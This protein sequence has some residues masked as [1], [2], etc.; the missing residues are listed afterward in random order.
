[1]RGQSEIRRCVR[2]SDVSIQDIHTSSHSANRNAMH[3][4]VTHL[5]LRE[6]FVRVRQERML[7]WDH[8]HDRHLLIPLTKQSEYTGSE[9]SLHQIEEEGPPGKKSP[10]PK[11]PCCS[12]FVASASWDSSCILMHTC[13]LCSQSPNANRQRYRWRS[14]ISE[15]KCKCFCPVRAHAFYF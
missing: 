5:V 3:Q 11:Q 9:N 7:A 2:L 15:S 14:D 1:M 13:H 10:L 4:I 8:E 6:Q 12:R